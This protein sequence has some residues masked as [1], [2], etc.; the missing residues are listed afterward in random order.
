[1]YLSSIH[2]RMFNGV[3]E[4]EGFQIQFVQ[5]TSFQPITTQ[6]IKENL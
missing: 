4:K 2:V 6:L 5:W 3:A 1:M